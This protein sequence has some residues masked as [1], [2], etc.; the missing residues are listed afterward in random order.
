MGG[1]EG[2]GAGNAQ[3]NGWYRRRDASEGPP[4]AAPRAYATTR[5]E[6]VWDTAGRPWY[7]KDD[8]CFIYWYSD[9]RGWYC[10]APN[11]MLATRWTAI[12]PCHPPRDGIPTAFP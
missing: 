1:V 10:Q 7:E 12:L 2:L 4:S 11:A 5:D 6:W 3:V 8:G 9:S